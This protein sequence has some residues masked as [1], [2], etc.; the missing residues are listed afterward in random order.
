MRGFPSSE[1][2]LSLL[3]YAEGRNGQVAFSDTGWNPFEQPVQGLTTPEKALLTIGGKYDQD[4]GGGIDYGWD[5]LA[6]RVNP[7]T[8]PETLLAGRFR[9]NQGFVI[10]ASGRGYGLSP[11]IHGFESTVGLWWSVVT[12]RATPGS[13]IL[14]VPPGQSTMVPADADEGSRFEAGMLATVAGSGA[15]VAAGT[16][17]NSVTSRAGFPTQIVLSN[18][19]T[20]LGAAANIVL[21]A[22]P[23]DGD[24]VGNLVTGNGG[25]ENTFPATIGGNPTGA[26]YQVQSAGG[27][28]GVQPGAFLRGVQMGASSLRPDGVGWRLSSVIAHRIMSVESAT[29]DEDGFVFLN[30]SFA[31]SIYHFSSGLTAQYAIEA[32]PSFAPTAFAYLPG[33]IIDTDDTV[34]LKFGRLSTRRLGFFARTPQVQPSV[35][36]AATDAATTMTLANNLRAAF[37]NAGAGLGLVKT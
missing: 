6:Y 17:I 4:G 35:G 28:I 33:Q 12:V 18:P 5:L 32:A 19:V 24:T 13:A 16:V 26:A 2:S 25:D 36:A 15:A 14:T 23:A 30:S 22:Y 8:K 20:G 3:Q 29:F 21:T 37:L 11:T 10:S 9:G 1:E 31:G 27:H 34:G 7:G